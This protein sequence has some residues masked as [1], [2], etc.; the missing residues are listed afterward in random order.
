[1]HDGVL[2][3]FAYGDYFRRGT[4]W[5]RKLRHCAELTVHHGGGKYI[6]TLA[7]QGIRRCVFD[8]PTEEEFVDEDNRWELDSWAYAEVSLTAD[9]WPTFEVWLFSGTT[10]YMEFKTFTYR[11]ERAVGRALPM[12]WA[13]E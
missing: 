6:Y 4:T 7:F 10:I 8:Y 12:R 11:R 1:M 9:N 13:R 3:N 2:L 5:T